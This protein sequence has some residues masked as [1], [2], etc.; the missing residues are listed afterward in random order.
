M[1]HLV[2]IG[3]HAA[4]H[5][6]PQFRQP[7]DLDFAG[8]E[9][10]MHHIG[11]IK[12]EIFNSNGM[13]WILE[14]SD[15]IASPDILYTLKLSHSFWK[16]NWPKHAKDI[17]FF[18]K[19]DCKIIDELFD[20][21]Y[22][23]WVEKHGSKKA[24]LSVPNEEFFKKTVDR[25][26]EHD[27]IHQAVAYYERPLFEKI[28]SDLSK[29]YCSQNLFSSLS[30]EDKLKCCREEIYVTALERFLIPSNFEEHKVIAYKKAICQLVTS[31]TKGWFPR[32]IM[33]NLK[34]LDMP[35]KNYVEDFERGLKHGIIIS[36]RG[37]K[38]E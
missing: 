32:F 10:L 11:N 30:F 4:K 24:K 17:V 18:Q 13:N 14:N 6:F 25:S 20:I 26:Y 27:T 35:D 38:I 37:G 34:Y 12:T 16:I 19:N 9:R 8:R 21:C 22:C 5:H 28:K 2:L 1:K 3:S 15:R 33:N 23:D 36:L 7:K 29:A 31:M